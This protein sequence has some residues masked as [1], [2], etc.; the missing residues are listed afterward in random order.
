MALIDLQRD[1]TW[2]LKDTAVFESDWMAWHRFLWMNAIGC[3]ELWRALW[4]PSKPRSSCEADTFPNHLLKLVSEH[5]WTKE[6]SAHLQ[7]RLL[8]SCF[9]P[10]TGRAMQRVHHI[11]FCPQCL[12]ASFHSPI[13]Q[14]ANVIR[15]PL[16]GCKL[17]TTCIGCDHPIGHPAFDRSDFRSPLACPNCH[18][19]FAAERSAESALVGFPAG[20]TE[21]GRMEKWMARLRKVQFLQQMEQGGEPFCSPD[22]KTICIGLTK[23]AGP[24]PSKSRHWLK[25]DDPVTI[26]ERHD[27]SKPSRSNLFTRDRYQLPLNPDF[28][29][30]CGIAKSLHRYISKRVRSICGH[31]QT[32]HLPW[33]NALRPFE[34]VQPVLHLSPRDCPCCAIL[35]QWRAYAGKFIT[36]CVRLRRLNNQAAYEKELGSFRAEFSLEPNTCAIALLSSFTW[37]ACTLE[38]V[39]QILTKR[40]SY[41]FYNN[42]QEFFD[43]RRAS[44][45]ILPLEAYRFSIKPH[46]FLFSH[47]DEEISL[48]FSIAQALRSLRNLH[49]LYKMETPWFNQPSDKN[50]RSSNTRTEA[51][52]QTMSTHL[53]TLRGFSEWLWIPSPIPLNDFVGISNSY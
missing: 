23:L 38:R 39:V 46:G 30:A 47:G 20:L 2:V 37:F 18:R 44:F 15:C 33:E 27:N 29:A 14:L 19:P 43:R 10:D 4:M 24:V 52:Y 5:P 13:F 9:G 50:I 28:S 16:H 3:E 48:M 12:D 49:T 34:P 35:D 45:N 1:M 31:R 26:M 36:F 53:Q 17:Q 40:Q 8:T 51:W 22:Y 21:F 32:S 7:R 41:F 6:F 25:Q 42:E 11:R